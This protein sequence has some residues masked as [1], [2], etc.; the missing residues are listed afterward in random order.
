MQDTFA[1][2][3]GDFQ[4]QDSEK[5]NAIFNLGAAVSNIKDPHADMAKVPQEMRIFVL[6]DVDALSDAV[7]NNEANVLL[8]VDAIRWL[9]GEESVAGAISTTEDVKIE[10][11]K[12]KDLVLFYGTIFVA[13]RSSSGSACLEPAFAS[14]QEISV[15]PPSAP[16]PK[17]RSLEHETPSRPLL[18]Q[19]CAFQRRCRRFR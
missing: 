16:L 2:T 11:T 14:R 8:F 9:G 3:N 7:F 6:G 12:Q 1:D 17:E 19:G 15:A 18:S 4:Q 13:P 5:K 10:H